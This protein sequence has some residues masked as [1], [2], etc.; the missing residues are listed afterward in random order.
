MQTWWRSANELDE[1]QRSIMAL[2]PDGSFVLRG[3]PGSGKTNLLLMRAAYLSTLGRNIAV[4]VLNR[5]LAEFI[6]SGAQAY[7][8]DPRCITTLRN[9]TL[10]IAR[11]AGLP[12]PGGQTYAEARAAILSTLQEVFER[13]GAPIFDAIFVD[14]AQDHSM[15]DLTAL[16]RLCRDFFLTTDSRQMIYEGGIPSDAFNGIV[17]DVRTLRYHYRSSPEICDLA[18][19]IG[20]TFS[21]GYE[22]ISPT[23][24]YP[25]SGPREPVRVFKG[26]LQDQAAEIAARLSGQIRA[27]R[28]QLIGVIAPR[29]EDVAVVASEL[30][31]AGFADLISVQTDDEGYLPFDP[32]RPVCIST[33]H[34]A[35]GLEFQA[36]H[37]AASETVRG[38]SQKRLV[39]TAV[40]RAKSALSIYH[41]D[42]MPGYL[43]SAVAASQPQSDASDWTR[44]FNAGN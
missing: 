16:S 31:T 33:V 10:N 32:D 18:D 4:V 23:S 5:N 44:V 22:R 37:F 8:L 12:V 9:L 3:P 41:D 34:A 28:G 25:V 15:E 36:V 14:E 43:R 24:R 29:K 27:Y 17:S 38:S 6:R 7:G 2:P 39:F 1:D 40:T 35:K 11:E 19:A 13:T 20:S 30:R 21:T 26:A 42:A